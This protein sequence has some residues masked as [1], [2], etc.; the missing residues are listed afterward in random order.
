MAERGL[1]GQVF[2]RLKRAFAALANRLAFA[3]SGESALSLSR[4]RINVLLL[5]L[6]SV[7]AAVAA[8]WL[9]GSRIES[10]ADAAARTAPPTASP[11][12]VPVRVDDIL[13][14][15]DG[16]RL[17]TAYQM[18]EMIGQMPPEA[19]ISLDLWRNGRELTVK[20]KLGSR[21]TR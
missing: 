18:I 12:L 10:P 3:G 20:A 14:R 11:I 7:A 2:V 6:G 1:Q 8:A 19:M 15:M 5:V 13:L 17:R 21:T 4:K 16:H 9:A